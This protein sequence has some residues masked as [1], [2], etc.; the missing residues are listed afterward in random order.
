MIEKLKLISLGVCIG[1]VIC[2]IGYILTPKDTEPVNVEDSAR[3]RADSLYYYQSTP[4]R[5]QEIVDSL[6]AIRSKERLK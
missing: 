6:S 1:I 3:N 5:Q 2:L 4:E